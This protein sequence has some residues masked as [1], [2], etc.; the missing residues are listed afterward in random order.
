MLT[1]LLRSITPFPHEANNSN[2]LKKD[3]FDSFLHHEPQF[4]LI[5]FVSTFI[6]IFSWELLAK[7]RSSEFGINRTLTNFL[8]MIINSIVFVLKGIQ[9]PVVIHPLLYSLHLFKFSFLSFYSFPS[10]GLLSYNTL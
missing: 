5:I 1:V 8:L 7:K 10:N 9:T 2:N 4:R 6:I 3:M